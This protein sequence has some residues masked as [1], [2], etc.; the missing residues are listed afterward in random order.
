MADKNKRKVPE[1]EQQSAQKQ[2]KLIKLHAIAF[3]CELRFI[4]SVSETYE[5]ISTNVA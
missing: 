2:T 5:C 3:N 1:T 4:V